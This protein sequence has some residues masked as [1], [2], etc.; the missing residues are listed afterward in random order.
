MSLPESE[1]AVI[2]YLAALPLPPYLTISTSCKGERLLQPDMIEECRGVAKA[3][4]NGDTYLTEMMGVAISKR[5]WPVDSPEWKAAAEEH[6]VYEYRSQFF[7]KLS[8]RVTKHAS[9]YL[10]L[11]SQNRR[12]Q[13]VFAAQLAAAGRDPNPPAH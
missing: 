11:C 3:L 5:V 2:G 13:E 12:E 7:M 10:A 4:Q 8:Y 1:V 9:E 6:R